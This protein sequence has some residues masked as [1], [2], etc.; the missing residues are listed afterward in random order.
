MTDYTRNVDYAA[1]D[2][3]ST[4]DAN[5]KIKGVDVGG[6]FD[7]IAT[8]SATKA[9]KKVP[10]T[11]LNIATLNGSTGDLEDGGQTMPSS[12]VVGLT[13]T[14]TLTNK[15][16]TAPTINGGTL[17]EIT[18][19]TFEGSTEDSFETAITVVDPT[20][21]RTITLPNKDITVTQTVILATP[22]LVINTSSPTEDAWT[23]V[24]STTLSNNGAIAAILKVRLT[25]STGIGLDT[26]AE[27]FLRDPDSSLTNND[28]T[29]ACYVHTFATT[30]EYDNDSNDSQITVV[31][32]SSG[33]IE[34]YINISTG[35]IAKCFIYLIGYIK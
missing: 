12:A 33:D 2:A 18:T 27:M 13:D 3:L 29:S 19:L 14:Q 8:S 17:N 31:T 25:S 32:N 23:T 9:N 22:E 28:I 7:E 35:T 20:A 26:T 34:Y 11:A 21:D 16:L 30:S 5:K 10:A 4:G 15:T 6:E 24:A 1:K